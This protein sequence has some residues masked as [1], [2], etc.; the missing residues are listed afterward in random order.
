[1]TQVPV[2]VFVCTQR[3]QY[4]LPE[5]I[6]AKYICVEFT[7]L[8]A[9]TYDPGAF[10]TP[11]SYKKMPTWVANFFIAQIGQ[12]AFIVDQV[13]VQYDALNFAYDYYLDD[14]DQSPA[15]PSAAPI[16]A[17]AQLTGYFN[18][19][20]STQGIDATTLSQ[21][22]LV[23]NTFAQ[24]PDVNVD[25]DS[26]LGS[27]VQSVYNSTASP[28]AT[29]ESSTFPQ[30]SYSTVSSLARDQLVYEN[31]LPVMY[32]FLTCRHSYKILQASFDYNRAYFAGVN[33]ISFIRNDYTTQ[34]DT[35]LYIESGGDDQNSELNDWVVN[36]GT[37][38]TYAN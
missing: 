4:A 7:N 10:A 18:S 38:Y 6:I 1:M 8:Q 32:F 33:Q 35:D 36:A 14:L 13:N 15:T 3:Q 27:Y 28:A 17:S 23:M 19:T 22:N 37:W 2:T 12:T 9:Q 26:V 5:P 29:V 21:I 25:T 24:T 30:L 16:N 11:V 20:T 34:A 31:N